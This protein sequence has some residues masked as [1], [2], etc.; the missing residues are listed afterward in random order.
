MNLE[1]IQMDVLK[2]Q[3][4]LRYTSY[5]CISIKVSKREN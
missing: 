4:D 1:I 5:R 2:V 3:I